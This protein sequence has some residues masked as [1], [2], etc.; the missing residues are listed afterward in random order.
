MHTHRTEA[1]AEASINLGLTQK[2]EKPLLI[3][4]EPF[5]FVNFQATN[6]KKARE[7]ERERERG[8]GVVNAPKCNG[9]PH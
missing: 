7:R 2:P 1:E 9:T 5:F 8:E 6:K 4:Q 3:C